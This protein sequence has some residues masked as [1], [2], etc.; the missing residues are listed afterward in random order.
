M[1]N[2][3]TRRMLGV[4]GTFDYEPV[5]SWTGR[6]SDFRTVLRK[7]GVEMIRRDDFWTHV[8]NGLFAQT[9]FDMVMRR[10]PHPAWK[11][12]GKQLAEWLLRDTLEE[13]PSGRL[14]LVICSHSHGGQVVAYALQSCLG[15]P[16]W[17]RPG[18]GRVQWLAGDLPVR[19]DMKSVYACVSALLC[20]AA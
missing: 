16:D 11:E 10:A 2:Y 15:D 1:R 13:P 12:G 9:A 8:V 17:E 5:S 19:K 4:R 7:L 3:M 6:S 20:V 18:A 14:P